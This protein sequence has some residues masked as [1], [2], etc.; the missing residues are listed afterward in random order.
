[1]KSGGVGEKLG[2]ALMETSYRGIYS[3]TAVED[4][5]VEQASINDLLSIYSLD[6]DAII[7]KIT[8]N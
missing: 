6:S 2:A 5:F 1:M 8:E 7:K 4:K 3:I